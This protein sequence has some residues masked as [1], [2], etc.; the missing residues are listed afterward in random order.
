VVTGN[1]DLAA[2]PRKIDFDQYRNDMM[3]LRVDPGDPG[4]AV[5]RS[6]DLR[7]RQCIELKK[8]EH[9]DVTGGKHAGESLVR[10]FGDS[11]MYWT[12][13]NWT[14]AAAS[15]TPAEPVTETGGAKNG[16][17]MEL[18]AQNCRSKRFVA[19]TVTGIPHT[20]RGAHSGW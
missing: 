12:A 15:G 3:N 20:Q 4:Y 11:Q 7:N 18:L 5:A 6:Y 10:P 1:G 16:N 13:A 17:D 19:V 8:G 14:P 9:V 2:C